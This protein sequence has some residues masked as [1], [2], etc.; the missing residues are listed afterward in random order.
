MPSLL[1][2]P[3]VSENLFYPRRSFAPPP[4]GARDLMVPVA[5]GVRLHA[6]L[7][8]A[9]GARAHVVLFHGNG[10]VVSDYD[11]LAPEYARLGAALAVIDYRGYGRSEGH[12]TLRALLADARP[13]FEGVREALAPALPVVIMGR[14]L[15]SACAAELA[16]TLPEPPAGLI[17]ESGF[18]DVRGFALR[19]GLSPA[20]ITEDDVDTIGPLKKLAGSRAPLLVL[21]GERDTLI[22]ADEGR[23]AFAAAG[24]SEKQLVIVP[25][26]GHNDLSMDPAY[27]A[28]MEGF[29]RRVGG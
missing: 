13:A 23:A 20:L 26:H 7:H 3:A 8:G 19:R 29:V 4:A 15:G 10:E 9:A 1:D 27:W 5:P 2:H 17:F 22:P 21:H 28:A 12:P 14:S 11:D 25:G 18:S 16:A 24:T 6:R